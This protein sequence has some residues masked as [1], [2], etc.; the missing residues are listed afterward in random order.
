MI[1]A[2]GL[3]AGGLWTVWKYLADRQK[4]KQL[5]R[6]SRDRELQ[7]AQEKAK[8]AE[9]EARKPFSERQLQIYF[10]AVEAA[11]LLA[12][13]PKTHQAYGAVSSDFW[14]LYWGPLALVEDQLVANAMFN[15]GAAAKGDAPPDVLQ[16]YA[17][18]LAHACR[19]SLAESWKVSLPVIEKSPSAAVDQSPAR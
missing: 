19:D 8:S 5:D 1:T 11:S 17:L 16:E 13:L 4:E 10:Q 14:K 12:T 2:V 15:F 3:V 18:K 7:L 6:A 9:V